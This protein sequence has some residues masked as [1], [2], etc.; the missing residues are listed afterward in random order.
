MLLNNWP[1]FLLQKFFSYFPPLKPRCILRSIVS[2]SLKIRYIYLMVSDIVYFFMYPLANCMFSLKKKKSIHIFCPFLKL[3]VFFFLLLSYISSLHTYIL[4]LIEYVIW[5]YFPPLI[6]LP[7]PLDG[8]LWFEV[9][10]L[11]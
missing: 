2:D 1:H 11:V 5:K 4:V 3:S 6:R 7:F 9:T 8:F 10:S